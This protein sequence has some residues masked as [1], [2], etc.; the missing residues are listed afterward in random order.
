MESRIA[1]A[2]KEQENMIGM[3]VFLA[4]SIFLLNPVPLIIGTALEVAYILFVP[5]SNWYSNR[6]ETKQRKLVEERR[7][8]LSHKFRYSA[9]RENVAKYQ[10]LESVRAQLDDDYVLR[11]DWRDVINRLDTLL[12]KYVE[13]GLQDIRLREY[14]T[15]LSKQADENINNISKPKTKGET[16][17]RDRL[18]EI[19]FN[20]DSFTDKNV[21][22]VEEQ[23]ASIRFYFQNQEH[24]IQQLIAEEDA[25]ITTGTGNINNRDILQKRLEIQAM[26]LNQ[27]EKIGQGLVNLNQQMVLMEETI[28]LINGQIKSKQPGQVLLD[29]E[30]LVNQ[31]ETVSNFL[32]EIA[33]FETSEEETR[34]MLSR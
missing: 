27:A 4:A 28:R 15:S 24:T 20:A 17:L 23:M 16:K 13:F 3:S 30:N 33:P 31:S 8:E 29:I 18:S 6:L 26:S 10:E 21:R 19:E 34:L 12:E 1:S 22:W 7:F 32:H 9:T 2:F 25:R 11:P 14:L 5:D